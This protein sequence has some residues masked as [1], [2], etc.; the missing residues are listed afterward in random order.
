MKDSDGD[1]FDDS[2]GVQTGGGGEGAT[3]AAGGF[4]GDGATGATGGFGGSGVGGSG[5]AACADENGVETG[6]ACTDTGKLPV[7]AGAETCTEDGNTG[8]ELPPPAIGVCERIYEVYKGGVADAFLSC[9]DDIGTQQAEACSIENVRECVTFA[10]DSACPDQAVIDVCDSIRVSCEGFGDTTLGTDAE[11]CT[12]LVTPLNATGYAQW[13]ACASGPVQ[14]DPATGVDETCVVQV[15]R[16]WD[17][18][19]AAQP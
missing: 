15:T 5:G 17:E 10:H 12:Y 4:G 7:A 1:D 11:T 8:G 3:G 18:V 19:A 6:L 13:E 16:C 14:I 9:A 2:T